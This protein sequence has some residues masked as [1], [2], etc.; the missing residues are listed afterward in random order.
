M[1][2]SP[3]SRSRRAA[4]T[5]PRSG[6]RLPTASVA[7]V[8]VTQLAQPSSAEGSRQRARASARFR[9]NPLARP[10]SQPAP[11]IPTVRA[12]TVRS[13]SAPARPAS[14]PSCLPRSGSGLWPARNVAPRPSIRRTLRC[15]TCAGLSRGRE[16]GR[17]PSGRRSPAASPG[18]GFRP[19]RV[20]RAGEL[21]ARVRD[22]GTRADTRPSTPASPFSTCVAESPGR[23]GS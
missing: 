3:A 23:D 11:P 4:R 1:R 15:P 21:R 16:P 5:R 8:S 2:A 13:R 10:T 6:P 9:V 12:S 19:R 22:P 14:G 20:R 7:R 17:A 18:D